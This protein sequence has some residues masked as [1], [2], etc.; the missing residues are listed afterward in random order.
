ML[1]ADTCPKCDMEYPTNVHTSHCEGTKLQSPKPLEVTIKF[2]NNEVLTVQA[3]R[4]IEITN[5]QNEPMFF[6]MQ[7]GLD[8]V[9]VNPDFVV[10]MVAKEI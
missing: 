8:T 9:W 2:V 7:S 3:E 5:Q 6:R 10:S 1:K 4:G